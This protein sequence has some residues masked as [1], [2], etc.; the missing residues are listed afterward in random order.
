MSEVT[1]VL[2]IGLVVA[3]GFLAY[4][5]YKE[6]FDKDTRAEATTTALRTNYATAPSAYNPANLNVYVTR[7]DGSSTTYQYTPEN[8]QNQS[9]YALKTYREG[10]AIETAL[11][12]QQIATSILNFGAKFNPLFQ[13][14]PINKAL[15]GVFF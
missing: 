8:L 12:P 4:K 10:G 5:A 15:R 2:T 11:L 1:D 14:S 6:V 7:P 13:G 3:G 9:L